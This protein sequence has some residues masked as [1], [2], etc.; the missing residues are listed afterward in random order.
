MQIILLLIKKI[1]NKKIAW[2]IL[3]ATLAL[4]WCNKADDKNTSTE[5]IEEIKKDHQEKTNVILQ[6]ETE[7]FNNIVQCNYENGCS[8]HSLWIFVP[9]WVETPKITKNI[10]YKTRE[11]YGS[12]DTY[13]SWDFPR[14]TLKATSN[15]PFIHKNYKADIPAQI[16]I[17]EGTSFWSSTKDFFPA[18]DAHLY[19]KT[20]INDTKNTDI[21]RERA[22][23]MLTELERLK[24]T[25]IENIEVTGEIMH[26]SEEELATLEKI[27]AKYD[28]VF[29]DAK[30]VQRE[31]WPVYNLIHLYDKKKDLISEEDKKDLSKII[32]NKRFAELE[33]TY[34][35]RTTEL[36][37]SKW[38]FAIWL[39][40]IISIYKGAKAVNRKIQ[41][42]KE[43]KDTESK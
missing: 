28:N 6:N 22:Y 43:I 33:I 32:D 17:T 26:F 9:I 15:S 42:I 21:A 30:W 7:Y 12:W 24:A 27:A 2:A 38:N 3:W 37:I 23:S 10:T 1:M 39:L 31:V 19:E 18:D 25:W 36:E 4:N 29:V 34:D 11:S 14:D 41:E 8:F 5:K 40:Y 13:A 16:H 35:L 20:K